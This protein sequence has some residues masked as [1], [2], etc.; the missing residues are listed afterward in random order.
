MTWRRVGAIW[1]VF[2]VLAAYLAVV[3][4][5]P[6]PPPEPANDP[7][8]PTRSLLGVR[9]DA[10]TRLV[11]RS[12]DARIVAARDGDRWSVG[13]PAGATTP[14]DLVAA[15]VA[16]LTAGQVADVMTDGG[17][18]DLEAVGLKSPTAEIDA[19][20]SDAPA[21]SRVLLGATNPTRTG[22]YAKRADAPAVYL[23]GLNVRYY[24]DLLLQSV[25][26]G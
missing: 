20:L 8:S 5:R 19:T 9:G 4:L 26:R 16:T 12:G 22:L 13:E 6:A 17:A 1:A 2:A 10:V 24:L 23:V 15:I 14:P 18:A 3:E 7:T 21:P 11:V 25:A